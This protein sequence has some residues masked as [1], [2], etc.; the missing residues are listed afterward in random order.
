MIFV[1]RWQ[2]SYAVG[3]DPG[4][5]LLDMEWSPLK[6]PMDIIKK[7]GSDN[8]KLKEAFQR[9]EWFGHLLR[10]RNDAVIILSI[11]CLQLPFELAYAHL[12]EITQPIIL[13]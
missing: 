1:C 12:Y 13:K 7:W 2:V 11:I 10:F 4:N 9:D 5:K 8:K 6:S 3:A